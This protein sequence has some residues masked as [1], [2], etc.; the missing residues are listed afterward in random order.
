MATRTENTEYDLQEWNMEFKDPFSLEEEE[1]PAY[2]PG[3]ISQPPIT[4]SCLSEGSFA[5]ETLND[6]LVQKVSTVITSSLQPVH[7]RETGKTGV[8]LPDLKDNSWHR[9]SETE[10]NTHLSIPMSVDGSNRTPLV[11]E[12]VTKLSHETNAEL[13]SLIHI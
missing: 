1:L 6:G 13:L 11:I 10:A 7:D 8:E 12:P 9:R 5:A 3:G 4:K 2:C